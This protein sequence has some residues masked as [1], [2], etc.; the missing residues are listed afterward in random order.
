MSH[1]QTITINV[2]GQFYNIPTVVGGKKRADA[3]AARH[4]IDNRL[5]GQGFPSLA[6]AERAA[7]SRS[8]SFRHTSAPRRAA[9]GRSAMGRR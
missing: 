2:D 6:E 3:A 4:A 1:E 7:V 8:Q 9:P 5:L